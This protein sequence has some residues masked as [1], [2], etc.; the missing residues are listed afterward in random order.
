MSNVI[1]QV[2]SQPL[3]KVDNGMEP[4]GNP[5]SKA[6]AYSMSTT[7][8]QILE[9]LCVGYLVDCHIVVDHAKKEANEPAKKK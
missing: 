7:V 8:A 4:V 1:A 6:G 5:V 9:E 2:T 3:K